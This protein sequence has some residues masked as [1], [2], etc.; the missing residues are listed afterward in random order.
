MR[1]CLWGTGSLC[2]AWL[3]LAPPFV[4]RPSSS[5]AGA[6]RRGRYEGRA[7]PPGQTVKPSRRT[8]ARACLFA[9]GGRRTNARPVRVS[10]AR[11]TE[12]PGVIRRAGQTPG[13]RPPL[14]LRICPGTSPPLAASIWGAAVCACACTARGPCAVYRAGPIGGTQMQGVGFAFLICKA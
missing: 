10:R 3:W 11:R 14:P 5:P 7:C 9:A 2:A 6:E 4:S 1:G 8:A 13:A 12:L